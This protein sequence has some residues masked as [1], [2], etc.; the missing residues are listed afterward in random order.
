M[1]RKIEKFQVPLRKQNLQQKIKQKRVLDSIE[2]QPCTPEKKLPFRML[3]LT[4]NHNTSL[5][6]H[7]HQTYACEEADLSFAFEIMSSG[8]Q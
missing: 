1:A 6:N 2:T 8:D 5:T 7:L 3:S 4:L